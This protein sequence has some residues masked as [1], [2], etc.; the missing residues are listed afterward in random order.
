MFDAYLY[1]ADAVGE[2]DG[3]VAS[4]SVLF[5]WDDD[6]LVNATF[7]EPFAE[8][9]EYVF[10]IPARMIGDDAFLMSDRKGG[11]CNPEIRLEYTID[12]EGLG[13][14]SIAESAPVN[15]YDVQGRLV[16]R[17]ASSADMK[18]L[19]KGIYIVGGK[20]LVVR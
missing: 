5:D 12:P 6:Y 13:V 7:A 19:A 15:V 18:T 14:G 20:K 17:N 11:V 2:E 16:L 3:I 10:V 1:R 4:A 8:K 9:G